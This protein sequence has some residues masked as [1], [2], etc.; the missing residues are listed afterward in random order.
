[1]TTEN[2]QPDSDR[3][4]CT[5]CRGTGKLISNL[6]GEAREVSCPWCDGT[7]QFK[8]E[9][10]AQEEGPADLRSPGK[11]SPPEPGTPA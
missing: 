11:A 8:A 2:A 10:D 1:M 3:A 5:P 9:H 6:G 7:G 4:A